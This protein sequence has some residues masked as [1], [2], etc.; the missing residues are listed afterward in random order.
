[1]GPC[2]PYDRCGTIISRNPCAIFQAHTPSLC[3]AM[4]SLHKGL[5]PLKTWGDGVNP[6]GDPGANLKSISH[7]CY[8]ILVAFAW[9]STKK[10]ICR[11]FFFSVVCAPSLLYWPE[12]APFS[13]IALQSDGTLTR[14]REMVC[15]YRHCCTGRNRRRS[16]VPT[17]VFATLYKYLYTEMAFPQETGKWW[18]STVIVVLAEIGAVLGRPRVRSRPP[19]RLVP[20]SNHA[21]VGRGL[22]GPCFKLCV[23]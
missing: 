23:S 13:Q 17:G 18:G 12:S 7:R 3:K 19:C 4:G 16:P 15:V 6:G 21:S 10:S 1:M 5:N 20:V 8:P 11:C 22:V 14:K 2:P 9:E